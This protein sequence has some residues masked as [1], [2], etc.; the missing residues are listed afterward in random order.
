MMARCLLIA[1]A[2]AANE[3]GYIVYSQGFFG[4]F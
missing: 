1:I 4:A 2:T 3:S